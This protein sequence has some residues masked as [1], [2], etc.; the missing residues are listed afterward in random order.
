MALNL[1]RGAPPALSASELAALGER[2]GTTPGFNDALLQLPLQGRDGR[3]DFYHPWLY[4][5]FAAPAVAILDYVGFHLNYAFAVLNL[6]IAALLLWWLVRNVSAKAAI[7]LAAGPLL[8]W[9]DKAHTEV[10]MF[11]AL[12][13]AVQLLEQRPLV[14]LLAAALAA[15]Q[16][17]AAAVVVF[18]VLASV[19]LVRPRRVSM[20]GIVGALAIVAIMPV[21]YWWHLGIASPLGS[22]ITREVPG[23]R[24]L[25]TPLIDPN[26]GLAPYAPVLIILAAGGIART[27][28][29]TL[30]VFLATATALLV[31]FAQSSNINHGGSPGMSRYGLW[32]LGLAVPLVVE[33]CR[34]LELTRPVLLRALVAISVA[35]SAYVF[36]PAW[37]DRQGLSPTWLAET[38][39]TKWPGADNPVPEVFSERM[40]GRDGQP[41]VPIGT[42]GCEKVLI[43]GDGV[44]AWWP[45]P[46]PPQRVPES[47]SAR[48]ALCYVNAGVV[49]AA[50]RQRRFAPDGFM[51]HAWT[52]GKTARLEPFLRVLGAS[53]AFIRM[54]SPGC[55]VFDPVGVEQPYIVQGNRGV[56]VW[57]R[58]LDKAITQPAISVNVM[59]RSTV[60]VL[61]AESMVPGVEP[62]TVS[63]GTHTIT[64]PRAMTRLVVVTDDR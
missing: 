1:S 44:D 63:A 29:R 14:A 51:H 25:V 38:I 19:L 22:T 59:G 53:P 57:T 8:W 3:Q 60:Q 50:P 37:S 32:L 4:S 18:M 28:R 12:A 55:R 41:L 11:V 26:L 23:F 39:W 27:P 43:R 7:V 9:I 6:L 47:C 52:I 58:G 61:D 62:T 42:V 35:I 33:G 2:L 24:A 17:P 54:G 48:D 45:F 49:R 31:V 36:R 30:I 13:F 21:Y 5:L 40:S 15:A 46:C 10:F 16:N 64:L 34:S 20:V 56:A